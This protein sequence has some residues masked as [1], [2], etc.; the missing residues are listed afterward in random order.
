[1]K[2]NPGAGLARY[3]WAVVSRIIA[4]VLGGYALAAATAASLAVWLPMTRVDAVVTASML[5]F[6]T[7]TIGVMW[8]F[9]ARNAWRAWSGIVVPTAVLA[10]LFWLG[11]L[12][13]M[14]A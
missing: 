10:G 12:A 2:P 13:G 14:T 3:R 5:G 4:A 6:V 7:Y 9:A 11:Q 1:M 8:V